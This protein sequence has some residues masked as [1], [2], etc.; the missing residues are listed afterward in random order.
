MVG[1]TI[2]FF[3]C[4]L[5]LLVFSNVCINQTHQKTCY[6]T[7]KKTDRKAKKFAKSPH[8][9]ERME[10][11]SDQS[12]FITL[13][14]HKANFKNNTKCRLIN[15]SKSEVGLVSKHYLSSIISTVAEKS[16]VNQWRNTSTVI[17]WFKNL[18]NKQKRRFWYCILLPV[19]YRTSFRKIY[20]TC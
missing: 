1:W 2:V 10:C 20:R 11:Y 14:D 12:A 9:D 18:Q 16:G 5:L 15:P 19:D 13:K 4:L 8:L 6:Q 17:K 3:C 7:N